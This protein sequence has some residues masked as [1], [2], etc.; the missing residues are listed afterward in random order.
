MPAYRSDAETQ[1]RTAVVE[2]LRRVMPC[3]RIIHEVNAFSFGNRIDV[4]AVATDRIVAVEIKSERDKLD[5]L[6]RQIEAMRG[7]AHVTIAALHQRFLRRSHLDG[8]TAPDEARG[9]L[10]W[11]YPRATRHGHPEVGQ[12]WLMP[13]QWGGAATH[14][15]MRLRDGS[16]AVT[17]LWRDELISICRRAGI[18]RVS[19][20]RMD[21]L[22]DLIRWR[23]TGAE[24]TRAVCRELRQRR[25]AEADPPIF[26][27][28]GAEPPRDP[29]E[30]LL[31]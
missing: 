20:L 1:I 21:E 15:D 26:D 12:R 11:V 16:K 24:I 22:A 10:V 6:E 17:M 5:R 2:E 14:R 30:G 23:L 25:C 13:G 9:A 19:A 7:I 28:C 27:D 3:A 18:E 31:G 4:L 8:L 29:F